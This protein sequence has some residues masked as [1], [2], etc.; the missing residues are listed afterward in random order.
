MLLLLFCTCAHADMLDSVGPTY[1]IAEPDMLAV[2]E[3]RLVSMRQSGE[4]ER[5][6]REYRDRILRQV[7]SP[8][9]AV[10]LPAAATRSSHFFDPAYI[11]PTEIR[12][13]GGKVV[14][15]KGARINPLELVGWSRQLLFVDGRHADQVALAERLSRDPLIRPVLTA[16]SY[17]R[18]M[19]RWQ[20]Q[21]YFDQGGRLVRRFVISALPAR[22]LQDGARLRI[23][24]IPVREWP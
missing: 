4:L 22:V 5:R 18:L 24:Q 10:E 21:V 13:H 20:R 19:R 11:A 7:E 12:D 14:V 17:T 3:S 6:Q 15:A 9:V 23:D 8:S 2:L 1:A 16:G